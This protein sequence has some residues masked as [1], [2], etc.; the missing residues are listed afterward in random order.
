[1]NLTKRDVKRLY[2][3]LWAFVAVFDALALLAI[4]VI[5]TYNTWTPGSAT[6]GFQVALVTTWAIWGLVPAAILTSGALLLTGERQSW[7]DR[8]PDG[9]EER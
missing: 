2:V 3:A 5:G 4:L 8:A 6:K 1:M 7:I 9:E